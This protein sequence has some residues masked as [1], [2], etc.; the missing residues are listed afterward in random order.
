MHKS[1][2]CP[3]NNRNLELFGDSIRPV[4]FQL[5]A[6]S[7]GQGYLRVRN[8][9]LKD[10]DCNLFFRFIFIT[11]PVRTDL[12]F[13]KAPP[14]KKPVADARFDPNVPCAIAKKVINY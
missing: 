10:F 13:I 3:V 12:R 14:Q 2:F 9:P 7:F 4:E 5:A 6:N 8:E 1:V 11:L